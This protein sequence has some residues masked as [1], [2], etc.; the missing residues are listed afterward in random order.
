MTDAANPF[1]INRPAISKHLKVFGRVC[2][3]SRGRNA[4]LR[5]RRIDAQPLAEANGWLQSTYGSGV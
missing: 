1:A 5:P 4:Q 3:I 2:P